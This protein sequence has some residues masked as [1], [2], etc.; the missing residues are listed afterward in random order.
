[1]NPRLRVEITGTATDWAVAISE[2]EDE[3]PEH[4]AVTIAKFSLGAAFEFQPRDDHPLPGL[5]RVHCFAYPAALSLGVITG[6][7]P[8]ISEGALLLATQIAGLLYAEDI[9]LNYRRMLDFDEPE[10]FGDEWVDSPLPLTPASTGDA[11]R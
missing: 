2:T 6:D 10:D 8:A 1:M 11:E 3:L 9:E 5:E 7:I 4:E